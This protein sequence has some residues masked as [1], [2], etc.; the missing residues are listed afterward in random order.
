MS[1]GIGIG[2]YDF[3]AVVDHVGHAL[4]E[5]HD[6]AAVAARLGGPAGAVHWSAT[7][8]RAGCDWPP[9]VIGSLWVLILTRTSAAN[10]GEARRTSNKA[11]RMRFIGSHSN[12]LRI[13]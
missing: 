8:S 6:E 13:A 12:V 1:I 11:A 2:T 10:A 3:V 4:G 5:V 9:T 7:A